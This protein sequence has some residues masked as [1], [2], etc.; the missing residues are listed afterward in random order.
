[1]ILVTIVSDSV[2]ITLSPS[3]KRVLW[4]IPILAVAGSIVSLTAYV[5]PALLNPRLS[6]S[7]GEPFLTL[8]LGLLVFLIYFLYVARR[9]SWFQCHF[10]ADRTKLQKVYPTG[11]VVEIRWIDMKRANRWTD[12]IVAKNGTQMFLGYFGTIGFWRPT[13][14]ALFEL[15]GNDSVFVRHMRGHPLN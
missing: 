6:E 14:S 15:A 13:L 1:M 3:E 7:R 4:S 12:V 2:M 5:H 11:D 10:V 8:A 9:E